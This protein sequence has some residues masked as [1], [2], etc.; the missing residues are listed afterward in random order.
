MNVMESAQ[1][2]APVGCMAKDGASDLRS[3]RELLEEFV[4]HHNE[5]A[6][7]ALIR[8]HGAMVYDVCRSVLFNESDAE[9]AFQATFL[10]LTR[11]AR[12]IRNPDV[13][14][15]WLHGVAHRTAL[16][17]RE[18]F[19]RCRKHEPK[20]AT[21]EAST[22]DPLSWREAKEVL[23]DELSGLDERHRAPL[24]LCYLQ[25]MTQDEAAQRLGLPK[26]TLRTRLEQGRAL[27]RARLVRRGLGPTALLFV[28]AWPAAG[29]A[30][31]PAALTAATAK[32]AGLTAAGQKTAA[33]VSTNVAALVGH[34]WPIVSVPK[35]LA[36]LMLL[37][38]VPV[39]LSN[40]LRLQQALPPAMP[41]VHDFRAGVPLPPWLKL[42]GPTKGAFINFADQGM[43]I[44][45]P[46]KREQ[47][48]PVGVQTKLV[49][50]GD[51]EIIAAFELLAA[52]KPS[53]NFG[54]GVSLNLAQA[55]DRNVFGKVARFARVQEGDVFISEFWNNHPPKARNVESMPSQA[56]LG[57]LRMV[58]K[59]DMLLLSAAEGL[60]GDFHELDQVKFTA[61]DLSQLRLVVADSNE[62]GV[63][64]DARLLELRIVGTK[65]T[66]VDEPPPPPP[67]PPIA[68]ANSPDAG[69]QAAA[70][71]QRGRRFLIVAI[72]AGVVLLLA[73]AA[74]LLRYVRKEKEASP[75]KAPDANKVIQCPGCGKRLKIPTATTG[76]AVKCPACGAA[77]STAPPAP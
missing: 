8:R 44:T 30:A 54:A 61:D 26:R 27:L 17:A 37:I 16:K 14:A 56:R 43:R 51:F 25:G 41:F 9:D 4:N 66:V 12:S 74:V 63:T 36:A 58:R 21:A 35:I 57:R 3:D 29:A 38:L 22:D 13:L 19:A 45:L 34:S 50:S 52:D 68:G 49:F 23:H 72:V 7:Q 31:A 33:V 42:D 64:V 77:I 65:L 20:A 67:P 32:A 71:S 62:P 48:F 1:I 47:H 6:F 11:N 28:L 2:P 40:A 10:I 76:K 75:P 55:A 69:P 5:T 18:R 70:S 24:V 53:K 46:A 60:A 39:G 59:G 15:S 73:A